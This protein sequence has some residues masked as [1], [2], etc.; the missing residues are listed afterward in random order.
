MKNNGLQF[1]TRGR[2]ETSKSDGLSEVDGWCNWLQV[3]DSATGPYESV[4]VT[5]FG[6]ANEGPCQAR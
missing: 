5:N 2:R 6:G 4:T 3:V 1:L